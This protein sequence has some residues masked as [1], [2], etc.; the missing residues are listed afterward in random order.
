MSTGP[1]KQQI[2]YSVIIPTLNAG[3]AIGRLLRELGEQS[4]KPKE[5]IVIDSDSDDDTVAEAVKAGARVLH[6]KREE[7]DHGGTRDLAIRETDAP[8]VVC[9]TAD[10]LPASRTSVACLLAPFMENGRV[11]VVGGRQIAFD[12]AP[13]YEKLVRKYN[14]PE[15]D[16]VWD[17]GQIEALGIRAFLV[18]D[19]FAAYRKSAYLSVGGFDRPVLTNEDMLMTGK[20]LEA[21]FCAAYRKDACVFHSHD[22]TLKQQFERNYAVG[23]VLKRYEDR[24]LNIRETGEGKKL[25]KNVLTGLVEAGRFI[26][27][28]RF[29]ADC[30]S[31]LLGNRLGRAAEAA[32]RRKRRK[33]S[34]D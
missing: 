34:G 26:D 21:G 1:E 6:I 15:T 19:V 10:A 30:F 28:L 2:E 12:T 4:V 33:E 29:A 5:I 18:S 11:A 23:R 13:H 24:F 16:R 17:S 9:M 8:F 27:C 7:F 31:R 14:Y 25:A 3:K 32:A 22:F 20:L